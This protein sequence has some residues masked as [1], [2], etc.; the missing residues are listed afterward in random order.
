M[1]ADFEAKNVPCVHLANVP[2]VR[3]RAL[4][5]ANAPKVYARALYLVNVRRHYFLLL[6]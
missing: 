2:E 1:Y 6:F 3:A 4:Y 5:L